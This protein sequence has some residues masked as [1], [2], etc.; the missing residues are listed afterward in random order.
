MGKS[1]ISYIIIPLIIL[2]LFSTTAICQDSTK[3][4][5]D[6][7]IQKGEFTKAIEMYRSILSQNKD[8]FETARILARLY[9]WVKEYNQSIELYQKLLEEYPYDNDIRL[10]LAQV[11]GWNGHYQKSTEFYQDIIA[12][13]PSYLDA[14]IGLARVYYWNSRYDASLRVLKQAYKINPVNEELLSL[15]VDVYFALGRYRAAK[16]YNKYL[17]DNLPESPQGLANESK[18]KLFSME[19]DY[20]REA[21]STMNDWSGYGVNLFF[22]Y[23]PGTAIFINYNHFNRFDLT[24]QQAILG[25]NG[26]ISD[27]LNYSFSAGFSFENNFLPEQRLNGQMIYSLSPNTQI[28]T[29]V[30][31]LNFP[32]NLVSVFVP[33]ITRYFGGNWFI[34]YN[35]YYTIGKNIDISSTHLIRLNFIIEDRFHLVGGYA[36]GGES[37]RFESRQD[38]SSVI[39]STA[40]SYFTYR[41]TPSYGLRVSVSHTSRRGSYERT[42]LSGGIIYDF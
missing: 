29:A 2:T 5:A 42:S 20:G 23:A 36:Y 22:R 28:G 34:D 30:N 35:Y 8:D 38:L 11:H 27:K 16:R 19:I 40:L 24:D 32:D 12:D 39:S 41:L 4:L 37:F 25:M 1:A 21:I 17:L 18:L 6:E 14:Y 31:F 3:K 15:Y 10:A 13:S 9:S 7:Y 33:S 26:P